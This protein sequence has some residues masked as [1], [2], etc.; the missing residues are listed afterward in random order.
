MKTV[1]VVRYID[2]KYD[3]YRLKTAEGEFI[4]SGTGLGIERCDT[5][6]TEKNVSDA[7]L[8]RYDSPVE[9]NMLEIKNI[10]IRDEKCYNFEKSIPLYLHCAQILKIL[11]FADMTDRLLKKADSE[12]AERIILGIT[13]KQPHL[14]K[15][16]TVGECIRALTGIG[17]TEKGANLL[18]YAVDCGVLLSAEKQPSYFGEKIE[19]LQLTG[20]YSEMTNLDSELRND[21]LCALCCNLVLLNLV[22]LC[23]EDSAFA[24]KIFATRE[25]FLVFAY[26]EHFG[27]SVKERIFTD[28]DGRNIKGFYVPGAMLNHAYINE[29]TTLDNSWHVFCALFDRRR[30]KWGRG[31]PVIYNSNTG[32]T[33]C[34]HDRMNM[35]MYAMLIAKDN[36]IYFTADECIYCYDIDKREKRTVYTQPEGL[37]L[38]EI[39]TVT[40]DGRRLLFFYGSRLEYI[41]DRGCILDTRSGE[42]RQILDEKWVNAHFGNHKNPFAG[43][44]II[45]PQNSNIVHFLHGGGEQVDD[46]MWL[47]DVGTGEKWEPYKIKKMPNG[48]FAEGLTHW[49]WMP[50]G[51][52]LGWVRIRRDTDPSAGKGGICLLDVQNCGGCVAELVTRREAIHATPDCSG[53]L[54]VYDTYN[55]EPEKYRYTSDISL[56]DSESG[57]DRLLHRVNILKGHPGHPHPVFSADGKNIL[58]AFCPDESGIVC[59]GTERVR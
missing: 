53:R 5:L 28:L 17:E 12:E 9:A 43:H 58:F 51:K 26:Y 8:L 22:R 45:N 20:L 38:Q 24:E 1:T 44:F 50:G 35:R 4:L 7:H 34:L 2:D 49:F 31:I 25:R 36:K 37:H 56:Y 48:E 29:Y 42:C 3:Y 11:G 27:I 46:R 10:E 39:P 18:E 57:N 40:D 33:I 19:P 14:G 30:R 59:V 23:G 55:D 13:G 52:Q 32:E 41:P 21:E 54:F 16:P 47:L 6:L 15:E